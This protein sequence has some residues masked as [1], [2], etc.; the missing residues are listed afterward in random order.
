LPE[1]ADDDF[2]I[3]NLAERAAVQQ[4]GTKTLTTLLVGGIG[5]MN[6]MLG[7]IDTARYCRPSARRWSRQDPIAALRSE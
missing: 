7:H 2:S 5:I 4:E 6:M 3:R 1:G